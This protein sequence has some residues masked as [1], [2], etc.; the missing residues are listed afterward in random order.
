MLQW[1]REALTWIFAGIFMFANPARAELADLETAARPMEEGVPQVAVMRLRALL[2][3]DLVPEERR[4][5]TAK[6]GEALLAAGE[7][8]EALKVLQD[9]AL[10]ALPATRFYRAQAQATLERWAEALSLYQQVATDAASPF[11]SRAILGQAEALRALRRPDEAL[12]VFALLFSDPQAKDRA[13]TSLGGIIARETRHRGR[14]PHPR[15]NTTHGPRRQEGEAAPAG[16]ARG[17][18]KSSRASP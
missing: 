5:A 6:L 2:S 14:A 11:R 1:K 10:L 18:T 8:E 13:R 17:T 7:A 16:P 9:P 3:G 12:Q 4:V 15:Q